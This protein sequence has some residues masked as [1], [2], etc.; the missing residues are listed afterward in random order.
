MR[1]GKRTRWL[2]PYRSCGRRS[3]TTR[4]KSQ[5]PRRAEALLWSCRHESLRT[6]VPWR[7]HVIHPSHPFDMEVRRVRPLRPLRRRLV[8]LTSRAPSSRIA[9]Q[10]RRVARTNAESRSAW[11]TA[12]TARRAGSTATACRNVASRSVARAAPVTPDGPS[13]SSGTQRLQASASRARCADVG[14]RRSYAARM[15]ATSRPSLQRAS[16]STAAASSAS[17]PCPCVSRR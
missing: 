2:R 16:I 3:R 8:V 7:Q 14:H 12:A 15:S 6:D 11:V 13:A 5:T 17:C 4:A 10:A 1:R 9:S